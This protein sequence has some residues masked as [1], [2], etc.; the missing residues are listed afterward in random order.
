M[1]DWAIF[2]LVFGIGV[3]VGRMTGGRREGPRRMA[4]PPPRQLTSDAESQVRA[5]LS[6]R[7]KIRAIK[8]YRLSTGVG[9]KDAKEAVEAIQE[10]MKG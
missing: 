1:P 7:K 5:L 10:R 3:L 4:G 6:Q 9:L 2:S 8:A